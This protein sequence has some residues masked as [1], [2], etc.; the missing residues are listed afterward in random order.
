MVDVLQKKTFFVLCDSDVG[1]EVE[2][3]YYNFCFVI[4]N[5][6]VN[7]PPILKFSSV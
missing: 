5:K 1:R 6:M 2:N 3:V 7:S 4:G